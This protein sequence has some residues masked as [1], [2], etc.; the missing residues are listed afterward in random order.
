[1]CTPFASG[2]FAILPLGSHTFRYLATVLLAIAAVLQTGAT[3]SVKAI[4]MTAKLAVGKTLEEPVAGI[5]TETVE[6]E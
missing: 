3:S 1:M 5:D 6:T 2:R 4:K